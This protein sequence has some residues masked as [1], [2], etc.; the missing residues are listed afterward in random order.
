M[1]T[2]ARILVEQRSQPALHRRRRRH[3]N[4]FE[5]GVR[6]EMIGY[7]R[8]G[9]VRGGLLENLRV[10]SENGGGAASIIFAL[11]RIRLAAV[12]AGRA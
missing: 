6:L 4:S 8:C 3:E 11:L 12:F 1:A 5:I 10:L 2:G 7:F 9:Q